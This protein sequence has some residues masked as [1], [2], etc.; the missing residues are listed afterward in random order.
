MARTPPPKPP[1]PPAKPAARKSPA[2]HRTSAAATVPPVKKAASPARH[3]AQKADNGLILSYRSLQQLLGWFGLALPVLLVIHASFAVQGLQP[4]ISDFYYTAMGDVLVGILAAIGVFLLCYRGYE[5]LP[6]QWLSDRQVSFVAGVAA[7]GVALFPV[8]RT[9][10]P[11]CDLSDAA[12]ITFGWTVHPD[13]FHYGSA[14]VFFACLAVFCL[15]LFTRGDRTPEG[16]IIWTPRNIFY[17]CC[18]GL[19]LLSMLAMAPYLMGNEQ[20]RTLLAGYHYLF[21]W[22][23]LGIL[24]FA[25]SWLRKGKAM[26]SVAV[27]VKQVTG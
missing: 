25:A 15:V 6:G 9:G 20:T 21:W 1:A 13:W 7:L 11:P 22:E 24:A 18:G 19:I 17:A 12:C 27:A 3:E 8:H 16:R 14:T 4:S 23:T 5:K 10:Q 2:R 26:D